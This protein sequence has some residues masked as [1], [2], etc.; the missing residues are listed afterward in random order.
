MKKIKNKNS[1]LIW[2]FY[3]LCLL[4]IFLLSGF[5]WITR[6]LVSLWFYTMIAYFLYKIWK[7][8]RK[9]KSL[10]LKDFSTFFLIRV[11]VISSI[12]ILSLSSFSIYHN[13]FSP[14]T[15]PLYTISNGEKT[16]RFQAMSHVG[17]EEFYQQ[18]IENITQAK[19]EWFVLF[20]E[21]VRPGSP[22]NM[23]A[24]DKALGIKFAPGLYD[25]FSKL[26]GIRAQDNNE[27]LWI[28]NSEDYNIDLSI[29]EIIEIY[30]QNKWVISSSIED[31]LEEEPT[32]DVNSEVLT[33]L[34]EL[35]PKQLT[36][37]R[38]INQGIMNFLVKNRSIQES[39]ISWLGK[40][41]IFSVILE[42]RNNHLVTE[43]NKSP[44]EKI[45]ITYGL[46]HFHGVLELL[47]SQDPNWQIIETQEIIL[48]PQNS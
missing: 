7:Y 24:F 23:E 40:E 13:I 42:D 30:T 19:R 17:S 8:I 9:Q 1:I 32:L 18:V 48:I 25:N 16:L 38:F 5:I 41:D 37:L 28:I 45:F 44:E 22:E 31:S 11:A 21:W 46:L 10:A 14:A 34:S 20:Y 47:Q 35:N 3:F 29:D 33:L 15:I 4:L 12:I 43:I 26:Y 39:F 6:T 27:F 36:L 2:T